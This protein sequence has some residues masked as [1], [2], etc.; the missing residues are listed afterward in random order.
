MFFG[1]GADD[2]TKHLPDEAR[3]ALIHKGETAET[4]IVLRI[5]GIAQQVAGPAQHLEAFGTGPNIL[6]IQPTEHDRI[7]IAVEHDSLMGEEDEIELSV[8]SYKDGQLESL[9]VI[10]RLIFTL[11]QEKEIWRLNE[12]T[13]AA[14][15]PLTDPDYLATLRKEQ[16]KANELAARVRIN[17]MAQAEIKYA[18]AHPDRGFDCVVGD[19]SP[20]PDSGEA[21]P[22]ASGFSNQESS[23]YR[24]SLSGC[25]GTPARRYRLTGVPVDLNA[26]AKAFC[27]NESGAIKSIAADQASSCFTQG[28]SVESVSAAAPATE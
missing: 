23:G 27:V 24:F 11:K 1:K 17:M 18:A 6:V 20:A 19:L 4:S 5:A 15:I 2:F 21:S 8:H 9:P 28:E 3:E 16:D 12:I 25:S 22:N 14:H 7:E 13:A 26:N 10:P